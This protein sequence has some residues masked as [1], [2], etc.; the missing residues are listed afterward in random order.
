MQVTPVILWP[1][2]SWCVCVCVR[3][4]MYVTYV[5]SSIACPIL[6]S[7]V[8]DL[9]EC[10]LRNF[11]CPRFQ[12]AIPDSVDMRK[13]ILCSVCL[14]WLTALM[15]STYSQLHSDWICRY[16]QEPKSSSS[17]LPSKCSEKPTHI[18][19]RGLDS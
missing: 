13:P 2:R 14:L 3:A 12:E 8:K 11:S 18:L 9:V 10:F 4:R 1:T 5:L 19:P 16:F 6:S 7:Q 17:G 15:L